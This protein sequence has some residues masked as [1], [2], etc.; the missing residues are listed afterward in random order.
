MRLSEKQAIF[1]RLVGQLITF[2]S[3]MGWKFTFGDA[4]RPDRKG[5][6]PNSLHYERLAVDLNLFVGGVWKKTSCPEW[7][8]LGRYWESLHPDAAWG[9]RFGSK[10]LN[11]FSLRHAG[12]A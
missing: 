1:C 11:H 6:A 10:D 5:H 8:T 9:G 12:T 7:Q 2:A 4:Y 3:S